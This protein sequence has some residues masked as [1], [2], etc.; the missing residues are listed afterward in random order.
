MKGMWDQL[1][2]E[3]DS[4]T[5]PRIQEF[6]LALTRLNLDACPTLPRAEPTEELAKALKYMS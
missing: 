5:K 1:P 3:I 2:K 6:E 4:K